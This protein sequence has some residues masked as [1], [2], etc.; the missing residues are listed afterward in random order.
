[1]TFDVT[2]NEQRSQAILTKVSIEKVSIDDHIHHQ[3]ARIV[4]SGKFHPL[5][6]PPSL[7]PYPSPQCLWSALRLEADTRKNRFPFPLKLNGI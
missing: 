7:P 1:M 3:F 5:S 6:V 4:C 2:L